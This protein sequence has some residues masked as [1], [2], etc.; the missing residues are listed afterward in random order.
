M[1]GGQNRLL[2]GLDLGPPF[3]GCHDIA[4]VVLVEQSYG[5]TLVMLSEVL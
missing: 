3:V 1:Y 2:L 4:G 5:K